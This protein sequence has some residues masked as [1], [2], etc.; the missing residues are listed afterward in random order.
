MIVIDFDCAVTA[1]RVHYTAPQTLD[2]K[3]CDMKT[4]VFPRIAGVL[5]LGLILAALTPIEANDKPPPPK[6]IADALK[7]YV[8]RHELAGAVTLVADKD[9]VLSLEAVGYADVSAS[10]PMLV[11]MIFWI[12]S[13][14]K[15]ITAAALMVLVDEGK[16]KL[17]DPVEKY[18]PEFKDLKVG[19]DPK[20]LQKASH[21]ITIR[22]VLS[23]T[24]GL[25]FGSP[26]ESPTIDVLPL[27][28]A[29][30]SY[31]KMP[32]LFQP[33]TG[34]SYS[35]AGINTAG[36]I[37]EVVS[38]MA[39]EDFLD[40]RLFVALGMKD[41]TFWPS[42]A[43]LKRLAKSYRASKDK[44]SLEEMNIAHLK[45]PLDDHKQRFACPGG[46]LFS[47]A[48]DCGVFCQM[49]LNG[50]VH[51]GKRILSEAAVKE[52][53]SRQTGK[54]LKQSYGLGW[55][56]DGNS[57][58]HGGAYS[59][60]MNV[61]TKRGLVTV[62]MVQHASAPGNSHGAFRKAADELYGMRK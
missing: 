8:D 38:G 55:S 25:K 22:E 62:W 32:L 18:L 54:D 14:S 29:V 3:G 48:S 9:K 49:M 7:P 51:K 5:L 45:Y 44:K 53:T 30:A 16:V 56:V 26:E 10:R 39:Y 59:T 11:E 61:D 36:R 42:E 23:H 57:F 20:D 37:I 41:T 27:K 47:T 19:K 58:G 50:G 24:S 43:Q 2:M 40:K 12:A 21:P 34:Y 13:M 4:D 17:D 52:M 35:N 60:N 33:G 46:G 31:P 6:S 28:D 1:R 15:P